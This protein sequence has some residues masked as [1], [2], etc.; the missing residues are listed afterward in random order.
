[1][2]Y[3]ATILFCLLT[4]APLRAATPAPAAD[5]LEPALSPADLD[6]A[7]C[8]SFHK[9]KAT[10]ADPKQLLQVLGLPVTKDYFYAWSAGQVAEE[11]KEGDA[12]Q[13]LLAFKKPVTVGSLL[14]T[15]QAV[16]LLKPDAPYP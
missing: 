4:A 1:M 14:F 3:V 12:F 5:P 9:G 15:T 6:V 11:S 16:A 10:P 2:R 13:Y 7:A 8:Q